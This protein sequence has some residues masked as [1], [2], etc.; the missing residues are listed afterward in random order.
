MALG[1]SVICAILRRVRSGKQTPGT[2][3]IR[4]GNDPDFARYL[5]AIEMDTEA[6]D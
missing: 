5:N 6:L 4:T 2:D 1:G 3:G